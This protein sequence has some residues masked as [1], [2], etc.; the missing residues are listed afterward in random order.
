MINLN[1]YTLSANAETVSVSE[2]R[3]RVAHLERL[4]N[5]DRHSCVGISEKKTHVERVKRVASELIGTTCKRAK[6]ADWDRRE[7]IIDKTA[8]WAADQAQK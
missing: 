5:C 7:R 6:A 2:F 4:H 1:E 8:T 3:D